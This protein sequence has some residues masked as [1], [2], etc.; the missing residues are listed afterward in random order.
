MEI[1]YRNCEQLINK[2]SKCSC[3]RK[4][5]NHVNGDEELFF[6]IRD[7]ALNIY[8]CGASIV[9][10][11][12]VNEGEFVGYV[13]DKFLDTNIER[14]NNIEK[15]TEI[16]D[17]DGETKKKQSTYYPVSIEEIYTHF[18]SIKEK[19]AKVYW[20]QGKFEKICQ[21]W[22]VNKINHDANNEWFC[23]DMEYNTQG[24]SLGRF[25]IIAI[26]RNRNESTNKRRICLI[27]LKVGENSYN[28]SW[29]IDDYRYKEVLGTDKDLLY[30]DE[31]KDLKY[32][33]GIV[34]HITDFLRFLAKPRYFMQLTENVFYML[35]CQ[36]K[37]G[38]LNAPNIDCDIADV[39][40]EFEEKPEIL[41]ASY[42]GF[43]EDALVKGLEYE[44]RKKT[45]EW[46]D[47]QELKRKMS[48][49]LFDRKDRIFRP[50]R[51][52]KVG[53]SDYN[54]NKALHSRYLGGFG[55]ITFTKDENEYTIVQSINNKNYK[56]RLKFIEQIKK[57]SWN[58]V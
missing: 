48:V 53:I 15:R 11:C 12:E 29:N 41:I 2:L 56:F 40:N 24:E 22:I 57:D 30:C 1:R 52:C 23:V 55:E 50:D 13:N 21:Q 8:C 6:G 47:T 42:D 25:D 3:G 36:R 5:I 17:T 49:V 31:Y 58:C 9:K 34:G 44:E 4:I 10:I 39:F 37:L 43:N 7:E 16:D 18:K 28:G 14:L 33:S 19:A 38:V 35:M 20:K 26:S 51:R 54:L 46:P 27:E 32:G 45:I